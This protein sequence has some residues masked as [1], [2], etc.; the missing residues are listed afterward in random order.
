ML[1]RG[2]IYSQA[3]LLELVDRGMARS[4]AHEAI[5]K[6]VQHALKADSSLLS[7]LR[8]DPQIARSLAGAGIDDEA[9]L[10]RVRATSRRLIERSIGC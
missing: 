4:T 2:A 1:T 3:L 9:L 7:V 8:D 5:K 6:A 10:D